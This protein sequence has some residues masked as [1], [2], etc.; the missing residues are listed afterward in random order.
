MS[1]SRNAVDVGD[2][3]LSVGT[4]LF[5]ALLVHFGVATER[6]RLDQNLRTRV[7]REALD[8]INKLEAELNANVFLANGMVAHI[9]AQG[10]ALDATVNSAL[11][12]LHQYGRHI[13]NIG[14]APDNR[15]SHIYPLQGNEAALG[16]YY[17]DIPNQWPA[18]K[19]AME[20]RK[21][22][23]AGPVPLRQGGTA[24]I[25]RTPVFMPDGHYWGVIGMALDMPGLFGAVGLEEQVGDVRYA[26]RGRDGAGKAG[27]VFL[28]QPGLFTDDA[29][30]FDIAIPG[31]SWQLAAAPVQGW[32]AT[33]R[34]TGA[35]EGAGM[36]LS[37]MLSLLL[38]VHLRNRRRVADSEQRLRAFLDTTRD[39][40]IV[41]DSTGL[42]QEFNPAAE[43]MFGHAADT[44]VGSDA[45]ALIPHGRASTPEDQGRRKDGSTFPIEVT[46][47]EARV[48]GNRLQVRV[49]RDI[50]ERKAFER[51]LLELATTDALTGA[52]NRRAFLE[53]AHTA[54]AVARRYHRPLALLML[55]ADH[56][57]RINDTYGHP[58]GDA[59]LVRLTAVVRD[60][61]RASDSLG[62][63]GGEEFAV[64][65][66][67]TDLDQAV[68]A[69]E[70]L[71]AAI[72]A[73]EVIGDGG[74]AIRFTVSIG[75]GAL[76]PTTADM[77]ALMRAADDALYRAKAEG[78]DRWCWPGVAGKL[79]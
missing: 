64:L 49:I 69:A 4:F 42:V 52:L 68:E 20:T 73:A 33:D 74:V 8:H 51:R 67:E 57:K 3:L 11:Q 9:V 32:H 58:M 78:R 46:V 18:V 53:A 24:L 2:L 36:V 7:S 39:A 50:T 12:A 59:V 63:L 27:D 66:P 1:K 30:T 72:R 22:V 17:P 25:S 6:S 60:C 41:T 71:L 44:M 14:I 56:F 38:Q 48:A 28:G 76:S 79:R 21:P 65:L 37:L 5:F 29:V 35:V 15:I 26:L 16:L 54:L 77:T 34:D 55:D 75:I 40:V 19:R 43:R 47:G 10:G 45:R 61:L 62:R 31:G 13:R 70:R 23:L